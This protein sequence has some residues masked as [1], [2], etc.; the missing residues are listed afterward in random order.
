MSC[1]SLTIGHVFSHMAQASDLGR[2]Q[3]RGVV[4]VERLA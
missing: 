3:R 4:E 2:T 1:K